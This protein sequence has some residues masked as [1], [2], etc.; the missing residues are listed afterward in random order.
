M[1]TWCIQLTVSGVGTVFIRM[2]SMSIEEKNLSWGE[3]NESEQS[4]CEKSKAF[5]MFL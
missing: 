2:K 4:S 3:N 5:L 1:S